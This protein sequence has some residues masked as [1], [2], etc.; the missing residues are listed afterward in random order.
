[1]PNTNAFCARRRRRRPPSGHDPNFNH[2]QQPV[3]G[4]FVVRGHSI[5]RVAEFANLPVLTV[6]RPKRNGNSPPAA[7]SNNSSFPGATPRRNRFPTMRRAGRAG[8]EPVAGYAPNAFGLYDICENVHEWCS[9]W[10]DP[11]YYA[12]S[13]ERNPRGPE[14]EPA[15][16]L[17]RRILATPHQSSALLRPL[18]HSARFSVRRLRLPRGLRIA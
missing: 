9:D 14:S 11:N 16:V 15:Q 17:S 1:M 6:C 5:L 12:V 4:A 10:Y 8:P 3:T 2:P 7:A 18:Q 13:P